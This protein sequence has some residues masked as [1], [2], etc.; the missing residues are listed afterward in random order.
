MCFSPWRMRRVPFAHFFLIT[1]FFSIHLQAKKMTFF[2]LNCPESSI[3]HNIESRC[4]APCH[5]CFIKWF[6]ALSSAAYS[7]ETVQ[8]LR[9]AAGIRYTSLIYNAVRGEQCDGGTLHLSLVGVQL[10][11][12]AAHDLNLGFSSSVRSHHRGPHGMASLKAN[13]H[14]S[15]SK[16]IPHAFKRNIHASPVELQSLGL[17]G[18]CNNSGFYI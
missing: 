5:W 2:N 3:K 4:H 12:L 14:L 13:K 17:R 11:M 7:S 18:R 16:Q 8:H 15:T 9:T 1:T 6:L 10:Q